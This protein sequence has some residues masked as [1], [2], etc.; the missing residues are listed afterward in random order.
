MIITENNRFM[1]S[2][3]SRT[4]LKNNGGHDTPYFWIGPECFPCAHFNL[5]FYHLGRDEL[6][7]STL[8]NFDSTLTNFGLF[9]NV[10]IGYSLGGKRK[11]SITNIRIDPILQFIYFAFQPNISRFTLVG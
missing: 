3:I 7:I 6:F 9:R 8:S 10:H 1:S 5:F 2:R 4:Y 11:K